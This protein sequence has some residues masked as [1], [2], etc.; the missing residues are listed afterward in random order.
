MVPHALI[1]ALA[2]AGLSAPLDSSERDGLPDGPGAYAVALH[3]SQPVPLA[4]NAVS[5]STAPAGWHVYLGSA[6]GPGG[7]KARLSRHLRRKKKV[8]WHVDRLT[9]RAD[10]LLASTVR[11]GDECSLVERLLKEQDLMC[12]LPGFGSTDCRT[13]PSHLLSF[14]P[15]QA[16]KNTVS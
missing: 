8:H 1:V 13:C 11:E 16:S 4:L 15:D 6:R 7:L 3:L 10:L 14:Q 12:L 2:G 5:G 9:L